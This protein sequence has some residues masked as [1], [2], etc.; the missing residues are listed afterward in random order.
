MAVTKVRTMQKPIVPFADRSIS[1]QELGN[2]S[3]RLTVIMDEL[4]EQML[5]TSSA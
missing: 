5:A 2:F 1:L 4:R 3:S